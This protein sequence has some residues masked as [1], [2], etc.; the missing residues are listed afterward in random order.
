MH[1]CLFVVLSKV[2]RIP[3]SPSEQIQSHFCAGA[4][5]Q[6]G[7]SNPIGISTHR[8]EAQNTTFAP[9]ACLL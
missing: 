4:F 2:I 6:H 5:G 7:S 8:N 3:W 9:C 1:A